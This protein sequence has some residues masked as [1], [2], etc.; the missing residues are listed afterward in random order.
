[1]A[2]LWCYPM[3]MPKTF[4]EDFQRRWPRLFREVEK[5]VAKLPTPAAGALPIDAVPKLAELPSTLLDAAFRE[6]VHELGRPATMS[7]ADT[8]Q[9]GAIHNA[10]VSLILFILYGKRVFYIQPNLVQRL[11]HTQLDI[12]C[13]EMAPPFPFCMLVFDDPISRE[14]AHQNWPTSGA[15]SVWV[16]D[17]IPPEGRTKGTRCVRVVPKVPGQTLHY[18]TLLF[19]IPLD[20]Q[21]ISHEPNPFMQI[22]LNALDYIHSPWDEIEPVTIRMPSNTLSKKVSKLPYISVGRYYQPMETPPLGTA[23]GHKLGQRV[24]VRGHGRNQRH[25]YRNSLVKRIRIEPFWKG[26]EDADKIE[27]PY[28]VL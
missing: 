11:A 2:Y 16:Q 26:P 3:H 25:G 24:F 7:D 22:V 8:D 27:R 21:H 28:V 17:A 9:M 19:D 6:H 4:Y 13:R 1:M 14:A 5:Y 23:T 10:V 15:I 12:D 20:D 18:Q